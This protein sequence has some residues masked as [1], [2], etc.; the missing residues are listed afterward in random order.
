MESWRKYVG[1]LNEQEDRPDDASYRELAGRYGAMTAEQGQATRAVGIIADYLTRYPN[2]PVMMQAAAELKQF[3]SNPGAKLGKKA[4]LAYNKAAN[5][6]EE[7]QA[8]FLSLGQKFQP[9]AVA[10]APAQKPAVSAA[11]KQ[12]AQAATTQPAAAPA[13]AQAAGEVPSPNLGSKT[14]PANDPNEVQ[15][16]KSVDPNLK[17]GMT[18]YYKVNDKIVTGTLH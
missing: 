4:Q 13:Q 5:L 10:Q 7:Q 16:R 8:Q 18:Y 2:D 14:N 11:E 1:T 15:R 6:P 3:I 12:P 17:P 9:T